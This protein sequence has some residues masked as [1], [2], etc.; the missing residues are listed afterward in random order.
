MHVYIRACMCAQ[1][2]YF[3]SMQVN[4]LVVENHNQSTVAKSS[5]LTHVLYCTAFEEAGEID[6]DASLDV[7]GGWVLSGIH[8]H[9]YP[10][11]RI[12]TASLPSNGDYSN[13]TKS[14]G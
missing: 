14:G 12:V 3:E 2:V 6:C 5:F 1:N 13:Y 4:T 11:M 10:S 9:S 7:D 8:R